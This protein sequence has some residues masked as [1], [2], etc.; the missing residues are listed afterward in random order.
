[1]PIHRV[2]SRAVALGSLATFS[3]VF[4]AST[5]LADESAP[6]SPQ[7]VTIGVDHADPANQQPE[8]GRVFEYTD[9][10]SRNLSVHSG[11]TVDFQASPGS[12]H[13]ITLARSEEVAR[14]V[15]PV[16]YT[17][18]DDPKGPNGALKIVNGPGQF[19]ITGGSVH[20]GGTIV[21]DPAA[22]P[23]CGMAS[24]GQV[25]CTFTGSKD[26]E[27]SPLAGFG[28]TGPAQQDLRY[29][30]TAAEG[31]YTYFCSIHP[32][33]RGTL[34]VVGSDEETSTQAGIDK[35]SAKQFARDQKSAL[36][37]EADAN[38][39]HYSGDDPGKFKG[40]EQHGWAP[41]VGK[42][43]SEEG[44]EASEKSFEGKGEQ[45]YATALGWH[46]CLHC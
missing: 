32:G 13:V 6:P 14:K 11:D 9:F 29:T 5:S 12:F 37:A 19:A 1:M 39:V 35:A 28:Q 25:P 45:E 20:G 18:N 2:L 16:G 42:E 22:P 21:T 38:E 10:F 15:Y 31:T 40:E 8:A 36:K 3:I 41:D 23:P 33:M 7:T 46:D 24:L 44:H 26:I 43:G 4:S 30:V 27:V 17:D 34:T